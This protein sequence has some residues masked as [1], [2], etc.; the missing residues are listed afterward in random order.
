M[1]RT[2]PGSSER[3]AYPTTAD[4]TTATSMRRLRFKDASGKEVS[5]WHDVPLF[6]GEEGVLNA[7]FEIPKNTKPKM[8]ATGPKSP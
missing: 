4:H 7:L 1:A 2:P 5:P 8:E 6:T 3:P